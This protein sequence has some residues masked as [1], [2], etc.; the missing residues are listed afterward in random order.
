[1]NRSNKTSVEQ[2]RQLVFLTG[3]S[4][5]CH[6]MDWNYSSWQTGKKVLTVVINE[7]FQLC[8][9][10]NP[11]TFPTF[12][13]NIY[14]TLFRLR[15]SPDLT[16]KMQRFLK[17]FICTRQHKH[18]AVSDSTATNTHIAK[19]RKFSAELQFVFY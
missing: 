3:R 12:E 16:W 4:E 13:L 5:G 14:N 9:R 1:M 7:A 18:E 15:T 19:I 17:V 2:S 10:R 11:K 8:N 6:V